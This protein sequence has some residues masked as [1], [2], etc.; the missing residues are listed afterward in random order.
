M[1]MPMSVARGSSSAAN[2]GPVLSMVAAH[3][4]NNIFQNGIVF[5]ELYG[6]SVISFRAATPIAPT[7]TVAPA[8]T[9]DLQTYSNTYG[10]LAP[11]TYTVRVGGTANSGTFISGISEVQLVV[12]SDDE[13]DQVNSRHD[14]GA[15]NE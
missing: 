8:L 7:S 10:A 13:L 12:E 4:S 11:G 2:T 6:G 1:P 3:H 15:I 5:L 14:S 9:S